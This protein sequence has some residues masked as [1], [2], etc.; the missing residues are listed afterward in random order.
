MREIIINIETIR[1]GQIRKYGES[2]YEYI[3]DVKGMNNY[4]VKKYCT[5][6]LQQCRQTFKE[7]KEGGKDNANIHFGGYYKF[8]AIEKTSYNEGKYK[9]FVHSPSTH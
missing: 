2:E 4:E 3:L 1:N 8:E 6:I 9:Y 5:M 7:W